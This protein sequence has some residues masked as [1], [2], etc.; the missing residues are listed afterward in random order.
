MSILHDSI[1]MKLTGNFNLI[2][3]YRGQVSGCLGPGMRGE[4]RETSG[5]METHCILTVVLVWVYAFVKTLETVH[6]KCLH[7]S[8]T[9]IKL[10]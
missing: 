2:Y 3:S 10:V 8:Y 5:V 9:S 6:L 4:K 7:L 1:Y